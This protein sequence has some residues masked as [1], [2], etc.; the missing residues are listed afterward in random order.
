M[1]T[2]DLPSFHD[3][4]YRLSS[5]HIFFDTVISISFIIERL[6][7]S[8]SPFSSAD[9][10]SDEPAFTLPT[11]FDYAFM[12]FSYFSFIIASQVFYLRFRL[13]YLIFSMLMPIEYFHHAFS[14][15]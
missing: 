3:Y 12:P 9:T 11:A 6:F 4:H 8:F 7:L 10:L 5:R 14:P 1:L 13:R 2:I 15:R